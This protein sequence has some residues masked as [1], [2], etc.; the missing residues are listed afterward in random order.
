MLAEVLEIPLDLD[1]DIPCGFWRVVL[2]RTCDQPAVARL[3]YSCSCGAKG[4]MF[5][6]SWCLERTRRKRYWCTACWNT[7]GAVRES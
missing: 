2:S 3:S 4:H 6:C 1:Q 5:A 7:P